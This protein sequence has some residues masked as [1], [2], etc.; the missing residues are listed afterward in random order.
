MAWLEPSVDEFG[1]LACELLGQGHRVR[2]RVAGGSMEPLIRD[3]DRVDIEPA[4]PERVAVGDVILF[5]LAGRL[6][7][8]R[9]IGRRRLA[10]EI[11][12]VARGDHNL[13]PEPEFGPEALLGVAVA[14]YRGEAIL[15][16][17]SPGM[18]WIGGAVA[19]SRLVRRVLFKLVRLWPEPRS[20]VLWP[21]QGRLSQA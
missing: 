12:L 7:L 21:W 20:F 6:F 3:G 10:E 16:L 13:R 19:R 5:S 8:H 15:D 17:R 4:A 18:R 11:C 9:V 2:L 14:L 1:A